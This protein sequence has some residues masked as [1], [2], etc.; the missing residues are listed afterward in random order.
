[1]D[2]ITVK[3]A[4]VFHADM[5][6]NPI[7]HLSTVMAF[8]LGLMLGE[9][10]WAEESCGVGLHKQQ[11]EFGIPAISWGQ[12]RGKEKRLKEREGSSYLTQ[13]GTPYM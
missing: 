4:R 3:G 9:G 10:A 7:F 1:M 2:A 13:V 11:E 8:D 12:G 6:I 5:V